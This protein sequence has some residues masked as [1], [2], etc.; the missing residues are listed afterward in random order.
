MRPGRRV[1]VAKCQLLVTCLFVL[2][3]G[4]SVATSATLTYF[5]AHWTVLR[6]AALGRTAYEE[7]HRWAFCLVTGLAV[8]LTMGAT[9]S[10]AGT[11]R[12]AQGLMAGGFLCFAVAF[13]ALVQ[14]AF[15]SYHRPDQVEE[16]VLDAFDLVY[17]R[18]LRNA[19]GSWYWELV[20]IQDTFLC[21]GKRSPFRVL[22]STDAQ[23]CHGAG[24]HT[25]DCLEGIR[26]FL[27]TH[28]RAGFISLGIALALMVPRF[29]PLMGTHVGSRQFPRAGEAWPMA[30]GETWDAAQQNP[31]APRGGGWPTPRPPPSCRATQAAPLSLGVCAAALLLSLVRHPRTP[32][33]GPARQIRPEPSLAQP[34]QQDPWVKGP[35]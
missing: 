6:Q 18:A 9:L 1:R 35:P 28:Q 31:G 22:R 15:Q 5:G 34:Q 30:Q 4:L 26:T 14:V 21:C 25:Q 20:A 11:M 23:L 7:T 12:E 27:R 17:D 10:A 8:L 13:C 24:T 2:L 32:R 33:P 29:C 16:V 19:T 3:L